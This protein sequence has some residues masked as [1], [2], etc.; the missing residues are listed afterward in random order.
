M[1]LIYAINSI[2][3]W[4]SLCITILCFEQRGNFVGSWAFVSPTPK[5]KIDGCCW[6]RRLVFATLPN[7]LICPPV[8][9]SFLY[10][11]FFFFF[12][13]PNISFLIRL[14]HI[15]CI[16]YL[17]ILFFSFKLFLCKKKKL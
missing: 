7:D 13:S 5:G 2:R 16:L 17:L 4:V 14:Y 9:A 15:D 10:A 11:L 12:F 3:D 8:V 6:Q 1:L